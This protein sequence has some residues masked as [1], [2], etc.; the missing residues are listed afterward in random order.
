L[1]AAS[2]N[3]R[4]RLAANDKVFFKIYTPLLVFVI[5]FTGWFAKSFEKSLKW[6]F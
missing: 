4:I 1:H 3:K 6:S 5:S 2:I